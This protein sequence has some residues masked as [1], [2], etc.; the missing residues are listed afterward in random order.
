MH[1]DS[2]SLMKLGR[3]DKVE[4]ERETGDSNDKGNLASPVFQAVFEDQGSAV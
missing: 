2:L 1:G 4:R 3:G